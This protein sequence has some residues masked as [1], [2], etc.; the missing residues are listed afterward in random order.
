MEKVKNGN[1]LIFGATG[2]VGSALS[3]KLAHEF[4]NLCLVGRNKNKLSQLKEDLNKSKCKANLKQLECNFENYSEKNQKEINQLDKLDVVIFCTGSH[5]GLKG[6]D[7]IEDKEIDQSFHA[8]ISGIIKASRDIMPSMNP[9]GVVIFLNSMS[10]KQNS[11]KNSLLYE[12]QKAALN[13][14]IQVFRLEAILAKVKAVEINLGLFASQ[15]TYDAYGGKDEFV[16]RF[17]KLKLLEE[18]EIVET[19]WWVVNRQENVFIS[20]INLTSVDQCLQSAMTN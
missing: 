1:A 16:R 7:Q 10:I 13:R 17:G 11:K 2:K 18:R 9:G 5:T 15:L 4:S 12:T 14:F 6:L 19:I 8:N 20:E 3:L